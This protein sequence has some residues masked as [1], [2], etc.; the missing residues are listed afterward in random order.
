[1]RGTTFAFTVKLITADEEENMSMI[2]KEIDVLKGKEA[3][4]LHADTLERRNLVKSFLKWGMRPVCCTTVEECRDF[5]TSGYCFDVL[6]IGPICKCKS[7]PELQEK[8]EEQE[9]EEEEKIQG[10]HGH[11][12]LELAIWITCNYASLPMIA[13]GDVEMSHNEDCSRLFRTVV[14]KSLDSRVIFQLFVN[15]FLKQEEQLGASPKSP[16]KGKS[17]LKLTESV[18]NLETVFPTI[19]CLVVED[20][21]ENR[22]VL[23]D[24]L[25]FLGYHKIVVATNGQEMLDILNNDM[26]PPFDVVL[27]DLLMPVMDGL[28]AVK[29]YRKTHPL[30]TKPFIVAVTAT[31]LIT[32]DKD[33]YQKA[34]M[35]AFIQK[36]IKM[37]QIKTMLEVIRNA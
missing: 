20:V 15:L 24:M 5:L 10:N 33:S 3:L 37:N 16:K 23:I 1:M 25:N 22:Q 6:L 4:I 19:R 7:S 31:N 35:D 12:F 14:S 21:P 34:G 2:Q 32:N 27:V 18:Q 30:G 13:V 28:T 9:E 8:K 29:E 17:Q 11:K 36:P 26:F